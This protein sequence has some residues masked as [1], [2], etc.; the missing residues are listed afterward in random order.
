[1]AST[2]LGKPRHTRNRQHLLGDIIVIA[3]CGILCK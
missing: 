3:I 1:M 2:S